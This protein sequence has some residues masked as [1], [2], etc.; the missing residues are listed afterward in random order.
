MPGLDKEKFGEKY[1]RRDQ[2]MNF[3]NFAQISKGLL[4][5]TKMMLKFCKFDIHIF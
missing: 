5:Y 1:Q 3:E 4:L 2:K